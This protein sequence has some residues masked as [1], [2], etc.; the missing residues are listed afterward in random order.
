MSNTSKPRLARIVLGLAGAAILAI[1]GIAAIAQGL[2]GRATVV[3]ALKAE[4]VVGTPTMTPAAIAAEA[5]TRGVTGLDFPTC[6]VAG[7]AIDSGT[8]ARCFAEYMRVDSLLATGGKTYA[9]MPRFATEDGKGT[10]VEAEAQTLPNGQ[11]M[12][13]PARQ[14]WVTSTALSNALN[15]SYMAQQVSL[16]GIA[17]GASFLLLALVVAMLTLSGVALTR[18]ERA[19]SRE[20]ALGAA[21]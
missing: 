2:D 9:E 20:P 7:E 3:D 18:R 17:V 13:N 19:V 8:K 15:T 5:K 4:K 21:A 10:N 11:P 1:F 6:S 16:F 14:V 12:N